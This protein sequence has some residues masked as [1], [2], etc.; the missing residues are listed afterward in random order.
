MPGKGPHEVDTRAVRRQKIGARG[1]F[2]ALPL[3]KFPRKDKAGW[4]EHHRT[5]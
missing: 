1:R 2:R 3:L 4:G 5:G